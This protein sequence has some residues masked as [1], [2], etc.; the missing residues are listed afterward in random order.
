MNRGN[1]EQRQILDERFIDMMYTPSPL[2]YPKRGSERN[3]LPILSNKSK[4]EQRKFGHDGGG[5]G[6][7][8][9]MYWYPEHGLGALIMANSSLGKG[10][11]AQRWTNNITQ[12]IIDERLVKRREFFDAVS[13]KA[14]WPVS[15]IGLD[16]NTFTPYKP[17]WKK[18]TG[19]Y[20][21]KWNGYQPYTY[22]KI[23]L[24]II[25]Y[26]EFETQ[27]YEKDGYL[28]IL[29]QGLRWRL[30][31]YQPGLFFTSEGECLDLHGEIPTWQNYRM[32]KIR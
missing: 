32:K 2:L 3:V 27:V 8:S 7:C 17:A 9:Y 18:Y 10:N 6:F 19:K 4:D 5:V 20:R 22:A 25:G 14:D 28:E 11:G 26:P 29:Y 24:A 23:L 16:P 21:I 30:D 15:P 31:E 13:L 1:I 12:R